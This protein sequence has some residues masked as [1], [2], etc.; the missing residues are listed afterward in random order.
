[1]HGAIDL[2]HIPNW[3]SGHHLS[4]LIGNWKLRIFN[5]SLIFSKQV[6]YLDFSMIWMWRNMLISSY[7]FGRCTEGLSLVTPP[8]GCTTRLSAQSHPH[9]VVVPK[10]NT[11]GYSSS[12]F[13]RTSVLWNSLPASCFPP[14]YNLHQFQLNICNIFLLFESFSLF[15][16]SPLPC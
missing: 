11:R 5:I 10:A 2:C 16:P 6:T 15:A 1:M 7:H 8:F 12:F 13:P 3:S 14:S 9:T 4:N